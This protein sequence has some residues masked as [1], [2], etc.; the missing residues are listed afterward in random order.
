MMGLIIE[1]NGGF[2]GANQLTYKDFYAYYH[3]LS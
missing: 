2:V 3:Y 1:N